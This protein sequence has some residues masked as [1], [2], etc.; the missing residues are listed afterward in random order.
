MATSK[1]QTAKEPV[2]NAAAALTDTISTTGLRRNVN[3]SPLGMLRLTEVLV[4]AVVAG[5]LTAFG[6]VSAFKRKRESICLIT[7]F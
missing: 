5:M 6:R 3:S 7:L 2:A 1:R 4:Q